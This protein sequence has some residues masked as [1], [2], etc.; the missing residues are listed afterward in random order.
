MQYTWAQENGVDSANLD[1]IRLAQIDKF[2]PDVVYDHSPFVSQG[3]GTQLRQHFGVIAVAWNAFIKKDLPEFNSAYH[4][5]VSLHRPFVEEWI[6]SGYR[7]A[8]LQPSPDPSWREFA[9]RNW[10]ERRNDLMTYGQAGGVFNGRRDMLRRVADV[11]LQEDFSFRAF[12]GNS[13]Q[14]H[15]P[16]GRLARYG[17]H[18]PFLLKWPKGAL[19][20]CTSNNLYGYELYDEIRNTKAVLNTF[21]DF[22][23]TFL[24]NMRIFEAIGNGAILISQKGQYPDGLQEG[25]DFFA[26]EDERDVAQIMRFVKDEPIAARD[27]AASAKK[28]LHKNFRKE[29]QYEKFR[30]FVATL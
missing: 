16:G 12:V 1:E 30:D 22:N 2:K 26:Y 8:E 3:F 27:F 23:G 11:T 17:M 9:S 5:Y 18:I 7:A 24:S 29:N 10:D 13:K 19:R 25:N 20:D 15:R 28:R 4:G 14:Y 6:R 21:G